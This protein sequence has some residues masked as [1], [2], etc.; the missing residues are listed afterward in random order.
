MERILGS[1]T[2]GVNRYEYILF[3]DHYV[4]QFKNGENLGWI[5]SYPAWERT[6]HKILV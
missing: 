6:L 2:I 4:Y 5:C 3:P 1:K